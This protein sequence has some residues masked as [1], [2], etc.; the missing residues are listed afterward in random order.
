MMNWNK[1]YASEHDGWEDEM[2]SSMNCHLKHPHVHDDMIAE[3]DHDRVQDIVDFHDHRQK[4][5]LRLAE[6]TG[7]PESEMGNISKRGNDSLDAHSMGN[8]HKI[9]FPHCTKCMKSDQQREQ[10]EAYMD[11]YIDFVGSHAE[12]LGIPVREHVRDYNVPD[13][14]PKDW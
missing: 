6:S 3:L 5:L 13:G 7:F 2:N 11:S 4:I 14:V 10:N 1:R 9:L 8:S 12:D